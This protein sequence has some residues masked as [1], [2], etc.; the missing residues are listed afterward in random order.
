MIS[1]IQCL[2]RLLGLAIVIAI[3]VFAVWGAVTSEPTP[4]NYE[5]DGFE[6]AVEMA[7]EISGDCP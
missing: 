3:L 1:F 6:C 5:V 4:C 7:C 2:S